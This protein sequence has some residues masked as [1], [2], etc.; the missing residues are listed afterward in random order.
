MYADYTFLMLGDSPHWKLDAIA[1]LD[2]SSYTPPGQKKRDKKFTGEAKK[3]EAEV[4]L[5]LEAEAEATDKNLKSTL[6]W[7]ADSAKPDR[8]SKKQRF[9]EQVST[10]SL[11]PS[12][13]IIEDSSTRSQDPAN[14]TSADI[15]SLQADVSLQSKLFLF[16][17]H[18]SNDMAIDNDGSSV[19]VIHK[20]DFS[21]SFFAS[22]A[23]TDLT[24]PATK[25]DKTVD[26]CTDTNLANQVAAN[27]FAADLRTSVTSDGSNANISVI[28]DNM[29]SENDKMPS[30]EM[31]GCSKLGPVTVSVTA[32]ELT[33]TKVLVTAPSTIVEA[34]P[35]HVQVD[36]TMQSTAFPK[37]IAA[38][39][40]LPLEK[41]KAY[42]DE[43]DSILGP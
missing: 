5:A 18:T 11:A 26:Q 10:T 3:E 28:E 12:T 20:D 35:S 22:Q 42:D 19:M 31:A 9:Q 27:N 40:K 38:Y 41:K 33:P 6:K 1:K 14:S 8:L 21:P 30:E 37:S 16:N 34:V 24:T 29:T 13:E 39:D 4:Q 15:V 23:P 7:P 32:A 43:R 17:V 2:Y 25:F 36:L